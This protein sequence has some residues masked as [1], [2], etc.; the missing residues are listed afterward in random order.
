MTRFIKTGLLKTLFIVFGLYLFLSGLLYA[1][2]LYSVSQLPK[3]LREARILSEGANTDEAFIEYLKIGQKVQRANVY[4][5]I[6]FWVEY[7]PGISGYLDLY[8]ET[9]EAA[10]IFSGVIT[11]IVRE[12]TETRLSLAFTLDNINFEELPRVYLDH[13]EEVLE[14]LNRLEV[15]IELSKTLSVDGLPTAVQ[16]QFINL[17]EELVKAE[18]VITKVRPFIPT[19]PT[20]LGQYDEQK[21]LFLLQN[22]HEL[23]P[24]GGFIGT[25]GQLTISDGIISRLETEDV[26]SYDGLILGREQAVPPEPLRLYAEVDH[27]YL[28]DANWSPDYPTS[29]ATVIDFYE[30]ATGD[31]G[32]DTVIAITPFLIEKFLEIT[33]PISVD[34]Q[35]FTS[36][37]LVD[38]LQYRVEQEF[39]QLGIPLHERKEIINNLLV[40]LQSRVFTLSFDEL[41]EFV[42]AGFNALDRNEILVYSRDPKTQD[43]IKKAGWAG[44]VYDIGA[45][46]LYIVDANLGALKTDR[47]MDRSRR[48]TVRADANGR[49]VARLEMQYTHNGTFDYRTTRYQSYTRA[50]VPI[51]S[52][53]ISSSG[54]E[55]NVRPDIYTELNKTVFGGYFEVEPGESKTLVY[56]YYLP[57]WLT[58]Q[59]KTR[60]LYE[61]YLQKQTGIES[62][63]FSADIQID[64]DIVEFIPSTI[65]YTALSPSSLR[66]EQEIVEDLFIQMKLK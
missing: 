61:I 58:D 16:V 24:T 60:G 32:T 57:E 23:R 62:Q 22:I 6:G 50:Y 27:W 28:R 42:D 44:Q 5:K 53:L 49:W 64:R 4:R 18:N 7:I 51:G 21:F 66:F 54:L 15:A 36:A 65:N 48:Y 39:W 11:D 26:Y 46:Y 29:A 30:Y 35:T 2:S 31:E 52:W 8:S 13:H 17:Q 63:G 10:S 55:D 38:A 14:A 59:F 33:G 19:I 12:L 25:I 56:E 41:L 3:E 37:N 1:F 40:S 45:D 9:L 34:G 20:I 47:V 43:L